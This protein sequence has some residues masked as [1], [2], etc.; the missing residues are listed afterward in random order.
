VG[1]DLLIGIV[2]E[3]LLST[4]M[5]SGLIEDPLFVCGM[6]CFGRPRGTVDLALSVCNYELE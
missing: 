3:G 6:M 4:K 1:C 2:V 5:Y